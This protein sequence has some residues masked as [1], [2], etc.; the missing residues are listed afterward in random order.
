MLSVEARLARLEAADALRALKAHYAALADAKYTS[1]YERVAPEAWRR[2]AQEQAACFTDDAVWDGGERFGGSLAGRP[3]IAAWFE[4]SPWRFALH[5]Y[6][7]PEIAVLEEER[8][9][10]RWR[11]WQLGLPVDA[12][13]PVL[14]AATTREGYRR[15]RAGWRIERMRF[16]EIHRVE[17]TDVP[18]LACLMAKAAS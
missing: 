15:T 7:A 1:A 5:Y 13:V 12:D 3:A 18:S 8:A 6:V 9:E 2:I 4:R 11:L 10:A 17:L 16:E 14:L